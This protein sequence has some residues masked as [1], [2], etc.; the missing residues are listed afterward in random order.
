M[1]EIIFSAISSSKSTAPGTSFT[2]SSKY[3]VSTP[4]QK[5]LSEKINPNPP[6]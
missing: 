1:N 4:L 2:I 6:V 5:L 3:R